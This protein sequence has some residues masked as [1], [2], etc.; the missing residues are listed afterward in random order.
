MNQGNRGEKVPLPQSAPEHP[1]IYHSDRVSNYAPYFHEL[2]LNGFNENDFLPHIKEIKKFTIQ[3]NIQ[4]NVF[5]LNDNG[6]LTCSHMEHTEED[7]F[8]LLFY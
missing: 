8:N 2:N 6:T 7:G 1:A 5:E 4:V 3:N